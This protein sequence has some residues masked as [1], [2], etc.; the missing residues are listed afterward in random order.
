MRKVTFPFTILYFLLFVSQGGANVCSRGYYYVPN[1]LETA[2]G[3]IQA[4]GRNSIDI[5]DELDKRVERFIYL[6]QGEKFHKG[7]YVRVYYHPLNALVQRII[8]MTVLEY[9]MNGQNLG[10][11]TH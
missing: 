9:K 11:I 1:G 10:F 3:T 8:R 6:E 7:D 4:I 2:T 5:Y